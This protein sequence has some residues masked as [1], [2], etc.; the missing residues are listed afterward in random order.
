MH[1]PGA[2]MRGGNDAGSRERAALDEDQRVTTASRQI[3]REVFDLYRSYPFPQ[4]TP[5]QR[6]DWLAYQ[7]CKYKFLG[8]EDAWRGRV[9]DVGCGTGRTMLVPGYYGTRLYV[10]LDQSTVSLKFAGQVA[11]ADG[12]DQFCPVNASLF[13]IPFS[14]N[15]F[16]LVVCWAVLHHTPDPLQGLREMVRVC[17]RG[18]F[19]G[20]FVY[21]RFAHWR[22]RYRRWR[23]IR[24]AGDDV[25][26]R[27]EAA[28]RLYGTRPIADMSEPDIVAFIDR[29]CVPIESSHTYGEIRSWLRELG[30]E[31]WGSSPPLRFRDCVLYL[32]TLADLLQ[33]HCGDQSSTGLH[34]LMAR[35]ARFS[36]LIPGIADHPPPFARPT[37]FH[38]AVWQAILAWQGRHHGTSVG[39][40]FAGR[41]P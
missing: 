24:A 3:E 12:V 13:E 25:Q 41:K 31:Y 6:R 15:T 19:V 4:T 2:A 1:A 5:Q 22:N 39:A 40:S 16:D 11:R 36:R 33:K 20:F 29:Y 8:V 21:N 35:L 30:L 10:G 27:F 7:I 23:V 34:R 26:A 18:G 28:H 17:K 32:R 38:H 14:D 9:L 37:R